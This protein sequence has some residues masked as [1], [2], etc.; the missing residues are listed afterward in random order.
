MKAVKVLTLSLLTLAGYLFA[1]NV[2]AS[3]TKC[4]L[5]EN[6]TLPGGKGNTLSI[7]VSKEF[8]S[9]YVCGGESEKDFE[10]SLTPEGDF[11]FDPTTLYAR[12]FITHASKSVVLRNVYFKGSGKGKII[13]TNNDYRQ[14]GQD[15]QTPGPDIWFGCFNGGW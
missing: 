13:I 9:Y 11:F 7:D 1:S 12:F 10:V 6:C 8:W 2:H 15:S 5:N 4:R 14:K 3:E